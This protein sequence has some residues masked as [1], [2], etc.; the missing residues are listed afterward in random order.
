MMIPLAA[1]LALLVPASDT[2]ARVALA[3]AS[4][5]PLQAPRLPQAPMARAACPPG[6]PCGCP[7]G[8]CVCSEPDS[9][10]WRAYRKADGYWYAWR[11]APAAVGEAARSATW[12]PAWMTPAPVPASQWHCVGSG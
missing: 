8:A 5:R 11:L 6:C 12:N 4:A 1:C 2:D 7:G 10:G 3:L 9:D